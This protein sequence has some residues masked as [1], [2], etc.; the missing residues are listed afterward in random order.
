MV[1]ANV[2][3]ARQWIEAWSETQL[4]VNKQMLEKALGSPEVSSNSAG[5]T[6]ALATGVKVSVIE[7][8]AAAAAAPA[9]PALPQ[10]PP[11]VLDFV[12]VS[13]TALL[14][15]LQHRAWPNLTI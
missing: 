6:I 1:A 4:S 11:M 8:P 7:P 5:E 3:E 12:K 2:Q 10:E 15:L 13:L 14:R 9:A